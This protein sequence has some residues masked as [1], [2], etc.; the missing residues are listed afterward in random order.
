MDNTPPH[1]ARGI[2]RI[3]GNLRP[4]FLAVEYV[5][6]A[7]PPP[8]STDPS[9]RVIDLRDDL[10]IDEVPLDMVPLRARTPNSRLIVTV[11]DRRTVVNVS[12]A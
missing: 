5:S 6:H 2:F 8:P 4:G 12:N 9:I 11:R 3:V 10:W 7:D 1:F